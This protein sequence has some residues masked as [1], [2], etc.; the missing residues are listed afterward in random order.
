[1]TVG[2][3][4]KRSGTLSGAEQTVEDFDVYRKKQA[5]GNIEGQQGKDSQEAARKKDEERAGEQA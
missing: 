1:M 5:D 4:L 2:K 3:V